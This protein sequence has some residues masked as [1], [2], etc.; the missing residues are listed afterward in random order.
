MALDQVDKH[1]TSR[2]FAVAPELSARTVHNRPVPDTW[3][4]RLDS[5]PR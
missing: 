3:S 2:N 5:H 1:Q 4:H